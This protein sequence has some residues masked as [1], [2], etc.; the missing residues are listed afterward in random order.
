MSD[1]PPGVT[2]AP[3]PPELKLNHDGDDYRYRWGK[4]G[5][6]DETAL[7]AVQAAKAFPEPSRVD[8]LEVLRSTHLFACSGAVDSRRYREANKLRALHEMEW[9]EARIAL[10]RLVVPLPHGDGGKPTDFVALAAFAL[11]AVGYQG[12]VGRRGDHAVKL[13]DEL[14]TAIGRLK[15]RLENCLGEADRNAYHVAQPLS[16]HGKDMASIGEARAMRGVADAIVRALWTVVPAA[17]DRWV[18]VA[19]A[20]PDEV[21]AALDYLRSTL[22]TWDARRPEADGVA[23]RLQNPSALPSAGDYANALHIAEM[24][25][26]VGEKLRSLYAGIMY[27][28]PIYRLYPATSEPEAIALWWPWGRPA[29]LMDGA[30]PRPPRPRKQVLDPSLI[31]ATRPQDVVR[32][33]MEKTGINRTTAQ[34]MTAALRR[35]MR[36]QRKTE[37]QQLLWQGLSKAE[38]ARRV[39]LSPSRIS[40]MFQGKRWSQDDRL[41]MISRSY[42]PGG[43]S[44]AH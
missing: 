22:D 17:P 24:L 7:S 12:F 15:D 32:E 43:A 28:M 20:T 6:T 27:S 21:I 3:P 23:K 29:P 5:G 10:N 18:R 9:E 35:E 38:V 19:H 36:S 13:R 1:L 31:T 30:P 44:R 8:P 34:R 16:Q 25:A 4:F 42:P 26:F 37:A 39:G 40:A 33:V 14:G 2:I 11:T 41:V